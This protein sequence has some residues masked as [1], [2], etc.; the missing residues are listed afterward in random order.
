MIHFKHQ[1]RRKFFAVAD[2]ISVC[3]A[4]GLALQIRRSVP[5]PIF[6]GLL[7]LG[8]MGGFSSLTMPA[9]ALAAIFVLTQYVLGIYDL[10][11]TSSLETW[12]K[13]LL[14][15][16]VFMVGIAFSYLYLTQNFSFP[17]SLLAA[18]FCT[19]YFLSTSWRVVYFSFTSRSASEVVLVG[20]SAQVSKIAREFENPPFANH[21]MVKAVFV[22]DTEHYRSGNGYPI[23]AI[24]AFD[25]YSK[26]N[27]YHSV[28]LAPSDYHQLTYTQ[29]ISAARRGV[30][31]YAIP[32]VYE[33]LLGRLNHLRINDLPL[34]E[35]RL[36]PPSDAQ[37][38]VKRAFDLIMSASMILILSIPMMIVALLVKL[39][40]S[41]P[42]LYL[43]ERIGKDGRP[44]TIYKF[45]SMVVNAES[46]TGAVLAAKNDPRVTPFGHFMRITRLDELPQ[47]FNIL[48]GEMSFVGPRPERPVFVRQ[49]EEEIV[50]YR[51]RARI[52]PGV[53]GLAQVSGG[54]E[55]TPE[56]KIKYDLSYVANQNFA[57][58]LKILVRTCKIICSRSGQ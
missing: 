5:I 19:N 29:I 7:P 9:V 30:A 47:L 45:R 28:I 57:L 41:G 50:G 34:L 24:S 37:L 40:S 32:T 55:T 13:R 10:W 8:N 18:V 46:K 38:V 48:R 20:T 49:F 27:P 56:I 1:Q 16:N 14:P 17:R 35:L 39:T 26:L 2:F 21:I 44:F 53:T 51:E 36:N 52:R 31:I 6:E 58:D 25:D 15:T 3:L 42:I 22:V 11:H 12:I 4:I 33:I 54:Y 43:Q 23:F